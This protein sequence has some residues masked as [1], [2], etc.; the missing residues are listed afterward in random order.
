MCRLHAENDETNASEMYLGM[1]RK[2]AIPLEELV[3]QWALPEKEQ[4]KYLAVVFDIL[5]ES[6]IISWRNNSKVD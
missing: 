5:E 4:D 6:T 3:N 2:R 1:A